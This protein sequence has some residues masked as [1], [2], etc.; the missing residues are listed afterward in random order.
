MRS[1]VYYVATSIDGFICGP[2]GDISGFVGQSDG[3]D[4][5]LNDLAGFDTVVMGRNTYEFG[6]KFGL[7]PG[8]P[9]Y[10]HM[11]HYIFSNNLTLPNQSEKI[12]IKKVDIEEVA[13]LKKQPGKDIYL[14]GGGQFA[15]W[16]LDN[17]L[18][19]ILKIKLNP[20]VLG[21]GIQLFGSS[22]HQIITELIDTNRYE[23]GLQIITYR[24]LY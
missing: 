4:K 6:Y 8:Q 18:I 22:T 17:Q 5:Y 7:I 14:C 20:L 9:A 15:G 3:V 23:N 19:D 1:I 2:N 24:L 10:P 13:A 16:L 21:H 12:I 11:T